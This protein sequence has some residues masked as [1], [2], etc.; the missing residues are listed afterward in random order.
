ML[1]EVIT[2]MGVDTWGVDYGILDKNGKLC[3]I[4]YHY[5]D[6]RNV[7]TTKIIQ[8]KM[9]LERLYELTG[10]EYMEINT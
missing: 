6:K 8:E 2:S 5:R 7:G 4:P 3:S 9:N 1:Y 10:I